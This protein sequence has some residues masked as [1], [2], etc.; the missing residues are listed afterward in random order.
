MIDT[1]KQKNAENNWRKVLAI[2]SL[3]IYFLFVIIMSDLELPTSFYVIYCP[4]YVISSIT[5]CISCI[6]VYELEVE[7]QPYVKFEEA[8]KSEAKRLLSE[9]FYFAIFFIVIRI[10]SN[11][12]INSF[13]IETPQN[14]KNVEAMFN[15]VNIFYIL[16]SVVLAPIMEEVMF[17]FLPAQFIKSKIPY[18]M[19]SG[20]V[21]A[22]LHVNFAMDPKPLL[23][24]LLYLPGLLYYSYRYYITKDLFVPILL[25]M[26]NN[27]IVTIVLLIR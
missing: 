22:G 27:L 12:L 3:L 20:L 25:H 8:Q 5:F 16:K 6:Q 26:F 4:I 15:T 14:Q 9:L 10:I 2:S 13:N 19:I 18:I 23:T 1:K 11:I 17:H 7:N 24:W 21:F